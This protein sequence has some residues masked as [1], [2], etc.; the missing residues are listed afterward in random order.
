MSVKRT[1]Y[2]DDP[3]KLKEEWF[4]IDGKKNVQHNFHHLINV[5]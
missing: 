4:E 5:V 2:D 1:F 3:T